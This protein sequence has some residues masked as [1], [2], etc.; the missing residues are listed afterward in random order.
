MRGKMRPLYYALSSDTR[1]L[2]SAGL[3]LLGAMS[4]V[5]P[6]VARDLASAF[7]WSLSALPALARPPSRC[8]VS[9]LCVFSVS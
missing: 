7:N 5:G 1:Q 8:V 4:R 3:L 2:A 6:G 9:M